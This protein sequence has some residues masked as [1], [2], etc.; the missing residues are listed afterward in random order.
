MKNGQWQSNRR[1]M[2]SRPLK[3]IKEPLVLIVKSLI[4]LLS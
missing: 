3:R 2:I 4:E 1:K